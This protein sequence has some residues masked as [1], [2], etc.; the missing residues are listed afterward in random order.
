MWP[1]GLVQDRHV[2]LQAGR[3]RRRAKQCVLLQVAPL[4]ACTL[5][6][7]VDNGQQK[8]PPDVPRA[9]QAVTLDWL[10]ITA[11]T[12]SPAVLREFLLR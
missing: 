8:R 10:M 4:K 3:F 5:C 6:V 12:W 9:V 2:S 1:T 11:E 7:V